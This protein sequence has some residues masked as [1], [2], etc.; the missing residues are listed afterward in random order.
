MRTKSG[1]GYPVLQS[2]VHDISLVPFNEPICMFATNSYIDI[3]SVLNTLCNKA[4]WL[5]S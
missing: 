4:A 3:N 1:L 2:S 5:L